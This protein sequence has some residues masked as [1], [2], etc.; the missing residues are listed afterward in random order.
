MSMQ[1][2]STLIHQGLT[3]NNNTDLTDRDNYLGDTEEYRHMGM[4]QPIVMSEV[5]KQGKQLD[6]QQGKSSREMTTTRVI[7]G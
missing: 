7:L 1:T 3:N 6:A 4:E 2:G 5:D